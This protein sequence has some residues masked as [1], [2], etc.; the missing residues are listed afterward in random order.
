MER[1]RI[2]GVAKRKR[3]HGDAFLTKLMRE[4]DEKNGW[5]K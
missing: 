4:F 3:P 2:Y 1:N 5:D